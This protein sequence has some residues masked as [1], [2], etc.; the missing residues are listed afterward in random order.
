MIGVGLEAGFAV[1]APLAV[2]EPVLFAPP[3]VPFVGAP[4]AAPLVGDPPVAG[5]D[6]G[7]LGSDVSGAGTSGMGFVKIPAIISLSPA[8]DFMRSV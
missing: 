6:D 5:V 7:V 2:A 4:L 8:V 3:V 1:P